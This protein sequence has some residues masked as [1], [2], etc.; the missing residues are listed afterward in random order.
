M[1][2]RWRPMRPK[3]VR[4]CV[5]IVAAHPVIGLRYGNGVGDLRTVWLRLLGREAFRAVVFEEGQGSKV[6]LVGVGVSVFVT[7]T[8]LL[9]MKT[10]PLFWVGPELTRRI[11]Q[12]DNP[13]L[14]D[15]QLR[16]ANSERG[17]NLV[18]WEGALNQKCLDRPEA[19]AAVFSAFVE[20]H[21]GFLLKE[22]VGHGMTEELLEGTLRSG[23]SLLDAQGNYVDSVEKPIQEVFASPH[24]V[25]LTRELAL[26]RTGSW[27][28]S[29][30]IYERPRFGL[31]PSEQ[32]LLL[33]A[34]RGGTD[35]ELANELG[36]SLSSV[37]KTWAFIYARAS[38]HLSGLSS[39]HDA[40][41][42]ATERGKEKKQRLLNYLREHPEELRPASP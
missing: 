4:E 35:D 14:S 30:F 38:A 33:T 11:M 5:N 18:T 23:G 17:L 34:L 19:K 3:D 15:K 10:P 6:A 37:E 36:V 20:Q 31:R 21:R 22:V 28:G 2:I 39:N 41:E 9:Q 1:G 24:Y 40:S 29:L 32:R 25:G 7:D 26:S 42:G 27:V 13:L 12:E 16:E 8:F